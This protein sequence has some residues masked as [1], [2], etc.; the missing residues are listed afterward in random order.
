MWSFANNIPENSSDSWYR[1]LTIFAI[2]LPI[3]GAVMGGICGWGAFIVSTRIGNLQTA[4]IQTLQPRH[5]TKE[6]KMELISLLKPVPKKAPVFFN[7]LMGNGEAV[8]FSD[9][10][11]E[12]LTTAGFKTEEVGLGESLLGLGPA[13]GAF[14]WF[15][16]KDHPPQDAKYISGA[17]N[18]VGIRLWADPQPDF[19]DPD[20]VVIVVASHP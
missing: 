6:Q 13:A 17:F 10:I 11:R 20:R 15:K 1:W 9:E 5:I 2:G 7:P 3:V 12:V 4:T 16:D 19:T 8:R 18:R 14:L